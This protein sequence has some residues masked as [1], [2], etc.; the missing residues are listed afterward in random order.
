MA[1]HAKAARSTTAA[2]TGIPAA[3]SAELTYKERHIL[4]VPDQPGHEI[5]AGDVRGR[6]K[7]ESG[8]DFFADATVVNVEHADLVQGT[9][10]HWGYYILTRGADTAVAKWQG[11]VTTTMTGDQPDTRFKGTWEYVRGSGAYTGLKGKGTY[12]GQFLAEDRYAV[13]WKGTRTK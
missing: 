7:N 8:D 11:Q 2:P 6:N 4:P 12:E 10:Q 5:R 3:G 9:G 1:T 13:R